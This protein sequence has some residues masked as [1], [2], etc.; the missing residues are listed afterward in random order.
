[1]SV[2][3][4]AIKKRPCDVTV[5]NGLMAA[6]YWDTLSS[7]FELCTVVLS[8]VAYSWATLIRN[9]FILFIINQLINEILFV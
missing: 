1:M 7:P 6:Q 4:S 2:M 9:I 8:D 3:I 5:P